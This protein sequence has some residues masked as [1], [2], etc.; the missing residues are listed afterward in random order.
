MALPSFDRAWPERKGMKPRILVLEIRDKER[1]DES[2]LGWIVVER[3]EVYVRD[4]LDGQIC[5]ASIRLSYQRITAR[6]SSYESGHGQ[7]D[8]SYSR[9]LNTV[10]LTSSSVTNGAVFLGLPELY[11]Q[12][13]GTYLMNVIVEWVK[14]WPD[15]EVN[16]IKLLTGQARGDNKARRNRFYEQFGFIFDYFDPGQR[17]GVSLPM[18]VRA[19]SVVET[20]KSNIFE[21]RMFDYLAERL[22][23]V[24]SSQ[25]KFS[26]LNEAYTYLRAE[27]K[28]AEACPLCWAFRRCCPQKT[29]RF[30]I[31]L[32]LVVCIGLFW[33]KTI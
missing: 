31:G 29:G 21:H 9:L 32:T 25:S 11:G 22:D 1:V 16:P 14:Q 4:P 2:P 5:E 17:E 19:L 6:H 15:A 13:V 7:F 10:S 18:Q 27:K 3:E 8:G 28:K 26:A 24:E 33:F 20:W 23:A 30:T 12:R